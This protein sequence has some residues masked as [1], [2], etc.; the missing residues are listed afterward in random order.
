M[1]QLEVVG[2]EFLGIGSGSL[3]PDAVRVLGVAPTV[4]QPDQGVGRFDPALSWAP[5]LTL[6]GDHWSIS[7]EGL[8]LLFEGRS[9]DDAR[10]TNWVYTGGP[11]AGYAQMVA[12]EGITIGRTRQDID[13][14]YPQAVALG[15]DAIDV[16]EPVLLRF[17]MSG[18][19]I[20]WFGRVD[21]AAD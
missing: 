3:L 2:G 19:T 10:L 4:E 6:P 12:P 8:T 13:A 20:E 16:Y 21:C 1:G 5:C 7:A 17:G 14:A 11:V 18:D 15:G 9:I